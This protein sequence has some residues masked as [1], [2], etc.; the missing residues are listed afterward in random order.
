[1]RGEEKLFTR[2]FVV[3]NFIYF[4]AFVNMAAFFQ[5]HRYILT[6]PIDPAS[7]GLLIGIF[8][9]VSIGVQPVLSP[10]IHGAN[11]KAWIASGLL[12]MLASLLTYGIGRTFS[13]LLAIRVIHGC[14]FVVLMTALTA[15]I[16]SLIPR[17]QSG[18]AFGY[19]SISM[20]L[21][22]AVVPP[23]LDV[24]GPRLGP[25][26]VILQ[27]TALLMVLPLVLLFFMET[28]GSQLDG[29][30]AQAR[31][32]T[33]REVVEDLKHYPIV[34]LLVL[35]LLV[36][37]AY[38]PTF[39]YLQGFGLGVGVANPGSFFTIAIVTMMVIRIVAAARFDRM[40]KVLLAC[41]S[42]CLLSSGYLLFLAVTGPGLF[43]FLAF[44]FGVAWGV[45]IPLFNALMFDLSPPLFRGL[46]LNLGLVMTQG[47]FFLGPLAG[48]MVLARWGYGAVFVLCFLICLTA[49]GLACTLRPRPG[50][51]RKE[52]P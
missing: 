3:M 1:M 30:G 50:R 19:L 22:Y 48:G 5:F 15:T 35:N 21:P 43:F 10:F 17:E 38:T 18:R 46:N 4:F 9:L 32:I 31:R 40:P 37:G 26:P 29:Q 23:I 25:F 42:L 44:L 36:Y 6:L 14:G 11:G 52:V 12:L 7:S 8:S 16:A 41:G 13:A 33:F 27:Y 28:P 39:F 2:N 34:A 24:V 47:G 20:L 45:A 51:K 49:T